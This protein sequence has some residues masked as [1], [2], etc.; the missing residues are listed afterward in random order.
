MTFYTPGLKTHIIDAVHDSTNFQTEFRFKPN[1]AYLS[2]VRLLNVGTVADTTRNYNNLNGVHSVIQSIHLFDGNVLLDQI[3]EYPKWSA[4]SAYN[5]DNQSNQDMHRVLDKN[6]Q[7]FI[8]CGDANPGPHPL[9]NPSKIREAYGLNVEPAND[10]TDVNNPT[11]KGWI[12]LKA[13]LP[14]LDNSVY[15][16]TGVFP[17][18][19]L[20]VQY[21]TNAAQITSGGLSTKSLEPI[22]VADEI[23]DMQ[24]SSS[25]N[26]S[27]KGVNFLAIEHDRVV[28]PPGNAAGG[29]E[30]PIT[31]VPAGFD[32]KQVHRLL[33]VN[34]PTNPADIASY[35]QYSSLCSISQF[36]QKI[37]IRVNGQNKFPGNGITRPME[38]LAL[39]TSTWGT[40]NAHLGSSNTNYSLAAVNNTEAMP[41]KLY[42]VGNRD[43]FGCLIGDFVQELQIDYSRT[44]SN[45]AATNSRTNQSLQLNLFGEVNKVIKV[46]G[47]RYDV[48][49]VV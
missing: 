46:G 8:H 31:F 48:G 38:R 10:G 40:C 19:R 24:R 37:Q 20:V 36:K 25:I 4:F 45:A 43:Y 13:V 6:M 47:G 2:N 32:N 1:T 28:V 22:L 23:T 27:Y 29:V 34:T 21:N 7:G 42:L 18:L 30:Q 16:P 11:A 5:Q 3:L 12:S 26:S 15:L 17:R 49:Y 33:I 44:T 35:A 14:M 39:L 41:V 9:A